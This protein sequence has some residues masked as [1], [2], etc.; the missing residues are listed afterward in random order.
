MPE[1]FGRALP[2][3]AV[4]I[5]ALTAAMLMPR[6]FWIM[7]ESFAYLQVAGL[8]QDFRLPPALPWPGSGSLGEA[9]ESL[10]PLPRHYGFVSGGRLYSQ[11]NPLLAIASMPFS[12]GGR[13]FPGLFVV[14]AAGAALLAALIASHLRGRGFGL[15]E[16]VLIPILGTPLF[17]F[18]QTF[19]GHTAAIFLGCCAF[20]AS[21]RGRPWIAALL[22]LPAA[23]LREE[24]LVVLPVLLVSRSAP[25]RSR[26]LAASLLALLLLICEKA[27]TGSWLGTHMGASGGEQ[28]LYGSVGMG[29]LERKAYVVASSLLLCLPGSPAALNVIAG[30]ALWGIWVV[31][32]SRW[33]QSGIFFAAGLSISAALLARGLLRGFEFLDVFW[34]KHPLLVFPALWL[35][36][37]SREATWVWPAAAFI[38]LVLVMQPQHVQDAAWGTRLVLL[39]LFLTVLGASRSGRILPV[40]LLGIL[41]L[42]VSLGFLG[43]RRT[44]SA[45]LAAQ[46]SEAGG[47]V[48]ATSWLLPGEFSLLQA[49]GM[50]VAFAETPSD[51]HTALEAL[52]PL[53]PVLAVR[54][55]DYPRLAEVLGSWGMQPAITGG[56]EFDPGLQVLL[57]EPWSLSPPP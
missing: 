5:P 31:S 8:E 56:E 34:L 24:S 46:A 42:C 3:A 43:T 51:L 4:L 15:R 19:W 10:R 25:I 1:R 41:S 14:P 21:I 11:Y 23:L 30:A 39:P 48:I 36:R 2:F 44:R 33:R 17:F 13:F 6:A 55:E 29:F 16:A 52:G 40:I 12:L 18:S 54:A 9:A 35:V 27:L 57:V 7:D 38:A 49:A 45:E 22:L 32:S 20:L 53:D 37:P 28:A 50:P 26:V 47:A